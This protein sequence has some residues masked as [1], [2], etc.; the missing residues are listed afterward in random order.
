MYLPCIKNAAREHLKKV[1]KQIQYW[2]VSYLLPTDW[3]WKSG[4]FLLS[5]PILQPLAPENLLKIFFVHVN[6]LVMVIGV[7][8]NRDYF[9][10]KL[11][12]IAMGNF[13]TIASLTFLKGMSWEMT[14]MFERLCIQLRNQ[15]K[16]CIIC[17][18]SW[19]I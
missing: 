10:L 14:I 17:I 1:Y 4:E 11:I 12:F 5:I 9:V 13:A 3:G 2:M 6:Q 7:A 8:K 18:V 19:C 16:F 15:I